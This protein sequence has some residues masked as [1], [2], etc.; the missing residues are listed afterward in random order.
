LLE[1]GYTEKNLSFSMLKAQM[2]ALVM[3]LPVVL[4]L[5][6]LYIVVNGVG[7]R[8][9]GAGFWLLFIVVMLAGIVLHELIHGAVG[10]AFTKKKWRSIHFGVDWATLTPYC[11]CAEPL[12]MP[13]YALLCALPT[14][15]L[16]FLP[17]LLGLVSGYGPAAWYGLLFIL[18]G[19]G[20]AYMLW[21]IR[22]ERHGLIL[23][24]PYLAGC[25]VFY[26]NQQDCVPL[27][28]SAQ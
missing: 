1:K 10:A 7:E 16:G 28:K 22:K 4:V 12:S 6:G 18:A 17:Y 9:S 21:L 5:G 11:H 26:P 20:D 27:T 19:G 23:D 24:H 3:T 2:M 13:Q 25:V 8:A 14:V 15:V